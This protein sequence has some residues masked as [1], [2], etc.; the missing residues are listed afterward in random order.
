MEVNLRDSHWGQKVPR[1]LF[2][3]EEKKKKEKEKKKE[4]WWT[5][6]HSVEW[7]NERGAQQRWPMRPGM[8][9]SGKNVSKRAVRGS[10]TGGVNGGGEEERR[11]EEGGREGVKRGEERKKTGGEGRLFSFLTDRWSR[12]FSSSSSSSFLF[13][14][15]FFPSLLTEAFQ[16]FSRVP[17]L[18][19][20]VRW[21]G[22]LAARK[23]LQIGEHYPTF[24]AGEP[25]RPNVKVSVSSSFSLSISLYF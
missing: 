24:S 6:M 22:V 20:G 10:F 18:Q 3:R 16:S 12:P 13:L 19:N 11:R 15:S 9:L 1:I 8:R 17:Q 2:W 23:A 25:K 7:E 5:K 14:S 21:Q 4:K